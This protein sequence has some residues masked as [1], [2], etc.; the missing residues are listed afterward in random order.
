MASR[1]DECGREALII[2]SSAATSTGKVREV[3]EDAVCVVCPESSNEMLSRGVLALVAD[4]MGGV[5]GGKC[6]SSIAAAVISRLYAESNER[7]PV[8]LGRAIEAANERIYAEGK[9]DKALSG[10]GTTCAVVALTPEQVWLA[11]VGDSRV[12]L[13][14]NR[15]LFQMT[16]DHSF[17]ASMVREGLLTSDQATCHE[18]RHVLTKVLGTRPEVEVAVWKESMPVRAGDRFLL[19]SDGLHD[20]LT[21][22]DLLEFG[23][24]GP[25]AE[26][27]AA[28]VERANELGGPDNISA[29]LLEVGGAGC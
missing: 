9:A 22:D 7:P 16:E 17:V 12:Y 27:A 2:N 25:V 29:V 5:N 18:E 3:N 15:Q 21:E 8:A 10:M 4:G 11:W 6:A 19:C 26:A 13:I 24:G 23:I 20:L 28:L 1:A 14:R